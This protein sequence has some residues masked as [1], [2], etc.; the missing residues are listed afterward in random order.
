[1][2]KQELVLVKDSLIPVLGAEFESVRQ[3]PDG[4]LEELKAQMNDPENVTIAPAFAVEH[5]SL[6]ASADAFN[7]Y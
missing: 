1:L 4:V 5:V 3:L 2:S 6:T 7:F